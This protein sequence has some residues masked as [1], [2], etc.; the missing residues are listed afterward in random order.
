MK[1]FILLF[2]LF[3]FCF[4]GLSSIEKGKELYEKKKCATCHGNQAEGNKGQKAPRLAGQYDWYLSKQLEYFKSGERENRA[5]MPYLKGIS[6]DDF[7][8]LALYLQSLKI[9]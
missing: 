3:P 9:D 5:M 4:F 8:H 6:G 1:L 2:L 7:D